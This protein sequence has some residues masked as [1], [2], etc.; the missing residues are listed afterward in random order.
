MHA[1][2]PLLIA[3][4]ALLGGAG[5]VALSG[6]SPP[7]APLPATLS[8]LATRARAGAGAGRDAAPAVRVAGLMINSPTHTGADPASDETYGVDLAFFGTL[9][10]TRLALE[11]TR[12]E[13]GLL[14]L[15]D[16][17]SFLARFADDRGTDLSA[18]ESPFGPFEMLPRVSADGRHLVCVIPSSKLPDARATHLSAAGTLGL[19]V[20]TRSETFTAPDVAL[21]AGSRFSVAGF[22]FEVE[23]AG[24][25]Q[26]GQGQEVTLVAR[27]DLSAIRRWFLVTPEGAELALRPS[28]SLSGGGTWSQT[29]ELELELPRAGVRVECW[30]DLSTVLVPFEVEAGLGLR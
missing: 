30:Q 15:D 2:F 11:L 21:A 7:P 3:L 27:R 25:S 26:W 28:M 6:G 23:S 9:E 17:A 4:A 12:P 1:R 16:G 18:S 22:D 5:V 29:L 24:K 13:G 10:R 19:R 20:A 8:P 14:G